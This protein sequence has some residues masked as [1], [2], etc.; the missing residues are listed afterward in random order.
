MVRLVVI[1]SIVFCSQACDTPVDLFF[2]SPISASAPHQGSQC[3]PFSGLKQALVTIHRD[4]TLRLLPSVGTFSLS[5]FMQVRYIL[6]VSGNQQVINLEAGLAV[7]SGASLEIANAT[8]GIGSGQPQQLFAVEG[9][10]FLQNC[11]LKFLPVTVITAFSGYV[12]LVNCKFESNSGV[13]VRVVRWGVTILLDSLQ[14]LR[15][16]DTFLSISPSSGSGN[17]TLNLVNSQV[18]YCQGFQPVFSI[19]LPANGNVVFSSSQFRENENPMFSF[20]VARSTVL[21]L[22]LSFSFNT[23]IGLQVASYLSTFQVKNLVWKSNSNLLADFYSL[24]GEALLSNLTISGQKEVG[25]IQV[26]GADL[27]SCSLIVTNYSVSNTD[28]INLDRTIGILY[29]AYCTVSMR[30]ISLSSV[31]ITSDA[32]S[33]LRALIYCEYGVMFIEDLY[34]LTSGSSSSFI[35]SFYSSLYISNFL[36]EKIDSPSIA[37]SQI[38]G[39]LFVQ[40]ATFIDLNM[41]LIRFSRFAKDSLFDVSFVAVMSA[42]IRLQDIHIINQTE[43]ARYDVCFVAALSNITLQAVVLDEINFAQMMILISSKGTLSN[44]VVTGIT[45]YVALLLMGESSVV[46]NDMYVRLSPYFYRTAV[47]CIIGANVNDQV[48]ASNLYIDQT[49]AT[50]LIAAKSSVFQLYNITIM[51]SMILQMI[52]TISHSSITVIG[53]RVRSCTGGLG[54]SF[55]SDIYFADADIREIAGA[56]SFLDLYSSNATFVGVLLNGISAERFGKVAQF[57]SLTMRDCV[58]KNLHAR[59]GSGWQLSD[60]TVLISDSRFT[61]IR[62]TFM[63][64]S[65]SRVS[66]KRTVFR[67]VF[68]IITSSKSRNSYGGVLGCLDCYS[69]LLEGVFVFNSSAIKGGA[70]S[71]VSQSVEGLLTIRNS[72]FELCSSVTLGGALFLQSTSMDIDSCVFQ[73]NRAESAGGALDL[74]V[75]PSNAKLIQ[76]SV[77]R[78]NTAFEGG[79]IKWRNAPLTLVHIAFHDNKAEYGPDLASYP[80]SLISVARFA[81]EGEVSAENAKVPLAFE[82]LDHYGKIVTTATNYVLTLQ[83][84]PDKVTFGGNKVALSNKGLFNFTSITVLAPPASNQTLSVQM[85]WNTIS[86]TGKTTVPFRNCTSGEIYHSDYCEYCNPGNVSF[87]PDDLSCTHCPD[88]AVCYGG[89]N[90]TVLAGYW[91]SSVNSSKILA[92]PLLGKCLGGVVGACAEGFTGKLCTECAQGYYRASFVECEKCGNA[93]ETGLMVAAILLCIVV[94]MGAVAYLSQGHLDVFRLFVL[95]SLI[96]HAQLL[97]TIIPFKVSYPYLI[98]YTLQTV[99]FFSS[100]RIYDLQL[101]CYDF[102]SA[103]YIKT[104]LGTLVLPILFPFSLLIAC[105]NLKKYWQTVCVLMSSCLLFTPA[106]ATQSLAYLLAC[107]EV[108]SEEWLFTD[109]S[110][111]CWVDAHL[112]LVYSIIVISIGFNLLLPLLLVLLTRL[113]RPDTFE[114]YFPMWC[115]GQRLALWDLGLCACKCASFWLELHSLVYTPLGQASYLLVLLT[116]YSVINVFSHSFTYSGGFYFCLAE[117]SVLVVMSSAGLGSFYFYHSPVDSVMNFPISMV[118]IGVNGGYFSVCIF[119]LVTGQL[120][121]FFPHP[122]ARSDMGLSEIMRVPNNSLLEAGETPKDDAAR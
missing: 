31:W 4:A 90:M 44:A 35:S 29:A 40:H 18:E 50:A 118:F 115:A 78:E 7:L 43:A 69:V 105:L 83:A 6:K 111:K 19:N 2:V 93:V 52:G 91:R 8:I 104:V 41:F 112:T 84:P 92:C 25:L 57:S 1:L 68:N 100:L 121:C 107:E 98:K 13:G 80:A 86:F 87:F 51:N 63:Q 89:N 47:Q 110:E 37:I 5:E 9:Q 15:H 30:N 122:A 55:Q 82:I 81:A 67:D 54:V 109:M 76:R 42:D 96:N 113:L 101:T 88:N 17:L 114:K 71:I 60:A 85:V 26:A 119:L 23:A 65:L 77:F 73:Y 70:L 12:S 14:L 106:I 28:I 75:D 24:T 34:A 21:L 48:T 10:L 61:A 108:N 59:T 36:A 16:R 22:N 27:S 39:S 46:I 116:S 72:T 99:A 3:D 64:A 38:F 33:K 94:F 58:W 79:A 32:T 62:S 103:E 56:D 53:M 117:I 102:S 120:Q 95:K 74:S 11:V 49:A 20:S 45:D 97:S 66:V